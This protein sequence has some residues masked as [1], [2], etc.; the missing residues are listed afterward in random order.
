MSQPIILSDEEDQAMLSTPLHLIQSKKRRTEPDHNPIPTVVL[1]DDD[2]TPQKPGPTFVPE[3]PTSDVAIVKCS[4][5][6][7]SSSWTRVSNSEHELS[8]K[9]WYWILMQFLCLWKCLFDG[10][11][12]GFTVVPETP[13]SDVTGVKCSFRASSDPH[14]KVFD[15]ENNFCGKLLILNFDAVFMFVE[16]PIWW[17]VM[18]KISQLF[19]TPQCPTLQL[20]NVLEPH[21]IPR[22]WSPIRRTSSLVGF[23]TEFETFFFRD[24]WNG[25]LIDYYLEFVLIQL[26][27]AFFNQ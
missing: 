10:L 26:L 15:L 21:P 22:L 24:C 25:Y 27:I 18:L 16:M 6:A 12:T 1:L 3:T 4:S 2:P 5:K 20:S 8:G 17:I 11:F 13:M 7:S 23:V 9:I 14:V 19:L